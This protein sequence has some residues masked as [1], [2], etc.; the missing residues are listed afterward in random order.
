M[1]I[2]QEQ[3]GKLHVT[4][5]ASRSLAG[6]EKNYTVHKL[7]FLALKWAI[8]S[9]FH[10]YLYGK[11]FTVFTD[12]NPLVY[13]TSTARLYATGHRW[14]EALAG[15]DFTIRY[16]P[17]K[18]HSD[19]DGLS[20]RLHPETEEKLS[21]KV[22]S[23][24]VFKEICDLISGDQEFAGVAESLGLPSN[25][26][27]NSTHV[28]HP[29]FVDWATEQ[30]RDPDIAR[31]K[32]LVTQ[33]IRPSNRQRKAESPIALR[34]LSYWDSFSVK[35]GVLIRSGKIGDDKVQRV[36]IPAHKQQECLCLIHDDMGHLGRDKTLS[37]AQERFFWIGLTRDVDNKVRTCKRCICATA[38]NLPEKAPLVSIITSRPMELVCMDFM[39]LETAVGGYH[40]ILVLTD[41]FIRYACA[42]PTRNQEARTVAKI[43]VDEFFVHYG[44]PE[45]LHSDQGAN[46][47]SKIVA[48]LCKMLGIKKSRTTP[49]HPQGDGMTEQFNKTLISILKTL[50]PIQ[51]PR[52][53]EHKI[54][55]KWQ[56]EP[57]TVLERP[58]PDIPVYRIKRGAEVKVVHRNLLLPVTLP[59][60]FQRVE[61]SSL[62]PPVVFH[63]DS[64]HDRFESDPELDDDDN[65]QLS[66]VTHELPAPAE[67]DLR[68][69]VY[70]VQQGPDSPMHD[71]V[72]P[73]VPVYEAPEVLLP[74]GGEVVE[75]SILSPLGDNPFLLSL[76]VGEDSPSSPVFGNP[77][78][79]PTV[80]EDPP[81]PSDEGLGLRCSQRERRPPDRYGTVANQQ[82]VV[83]SD[84][85]DRIS[86]LLSL[87]NVFPGQQAEIFSAMMHVMKG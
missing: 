69:E 32:H 25:V 55:D 28:S 13:V 8:T 27:C 30:D 60:D 4:A 18:T 82:V 2:Y 48:H 68:E 72:E 44:I 36:V 24:E 15:Y 73:V 76:P 21:S 75:D 14:L 52:W 19:A 64:M 5:Y 37:V 85:R 78:L 33:G 66:V 7:E 45:R 49:Y 83:Q 79:A 40:S 42:F 50:D 31:V 38:P 80:V 65:L 3:D 57:F 16:K 9:K 81:P 22:I 58:N 12:H 23:P 74:V 71:A 46:F 47:Q 51:K 35:N 1:A 34:L 61:S 56:Q 53:K 10:Q 29:V 59:F 41:H 17:G 20:R 67:I 70:D 26:V 86:I 63:D 11:K 77:L 87:L 39:S 62:R 43:L 84:W 6:S 54:A